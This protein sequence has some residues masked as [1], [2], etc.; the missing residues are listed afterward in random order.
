ME[1]T[2]IYLGYG[3]LDFEVPM[4]KFNELKTDRGRV[5]LCQKMIDKYCQSLIGKVVQGIEVRKIK[6]NTYIVPLRINDLNYSCNNKVP[7]DES[8][9]V[10]R[11]S[12]LELVG[13][14]IDPIKVEENPFIRIENQ[15]FYL[16][17]GSY[18][19]V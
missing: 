11:V 1:K 18:E 8:K 15:K 16:R 10:C 17:I 6:C 4:K 2:Q 12:T 5:R 13:V 3:G 19:I 7:K 9:M 14:A